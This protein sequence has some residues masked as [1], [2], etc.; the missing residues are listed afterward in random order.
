M[1]GLFYGFCHQKTKSFF[2]LPQNNPR[3]KSKFFHYIATLISK[4][5]F[6]PIK[7]TGIKRIPRFVSPK[8]PLG[9]SWVFSRLLSDLWSPMARCPRVVEQKA[10]NARTLRKAVA[11]LRHG[12]FPMR[13]FFQAYLP[14]QHICFKNLRGSSIFG[15]KFDEA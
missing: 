12:G 10:P 14:F 1:D 8:K 5:L 2:H 15:V 11:V 7:N 6:K 3:S 4:N 9:K 13:N